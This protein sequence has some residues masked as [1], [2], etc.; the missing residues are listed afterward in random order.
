MS[1]Y[2]YIDIILTIIVVIMAFHGFMQG[3]IKEFFSLGAPAL[4]ILGGFLFHKP[5]AEML[6][7]QF[8]NDIPGLPEVLAFIGIFLIVFI[9]CK[10]CQKFLSNIINGMKLTSLDKMLGCIFGVIE[11]FA[12]IS[13]IVFL[14]DKQPFF[15][16]DP[17]LRSSL[18]GKVLLPLLSRTIIWPNHEEP[19]LMPNT[20]LNYLRS[21]FFAG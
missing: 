13:L 10:M 1:E 6:R 3:F 12:V 15:D 2:A 4:G 11:G 8:H 18:Y 20:V 16:S 14:I 17:I 9:I 7:T 5:G 19:G 21:G